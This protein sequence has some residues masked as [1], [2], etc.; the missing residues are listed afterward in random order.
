M[1]QSKVH[2]PL[3]DTYTENHFHEKLRTSLSRLVKT[4]QNLNLLKSKVVDYTVDLEN[5]EHHGQQINPQVETTK[6][7]CNVLETLLRYSECVDRFTPIILIFN[8]SF[9]KTI[10]DKIKDIEKVFKNLWL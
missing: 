9:T 2:R 7:I 8:L 10:L 3:S 5:F 1:A 6:I 4:F